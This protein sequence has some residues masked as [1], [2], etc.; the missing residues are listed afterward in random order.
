MTTATLSLDD[1]QACHQLTVIE[2]LM[3]GPGGLN[4]CLSCR[5]ATQNAIADPRR[6]VRERVGPRK[7]PLTAGGLAAHFALFAA[8]FSGLIHYTWGPDLAITALM[9]SGLALAGLIPV[10]RARMLPR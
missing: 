6:S 3:M 8:G 7:A 2:Q 10:I 4:M 9:G 1:C 5:L